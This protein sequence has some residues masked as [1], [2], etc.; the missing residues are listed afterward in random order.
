IHNMVSSPCHLL[1]H[2]ILILSPST[3]YFLRCSFYSLYRLFCFTSSFLH[4]W[5]ALFLFPSFLSTHTLTF[6]RLLLS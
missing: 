4:Y 6:L 1:G 5:S 2:L 3:L